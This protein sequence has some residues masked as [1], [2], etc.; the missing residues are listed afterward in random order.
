M[1]DNKTKMPDMSYNL[2]IRRQVQNRHIEGTKEY[3]QYTD[4]LSV[5]GLKPSKLNSDVDIQNL[6]KEFHKQGKYDPNHKDSSPREIVDVGR[7]IGQYWD[8]E[9]QKFIDTSFVKI[10]YSKKGTHI[11]PIKPRGDEK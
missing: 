4:R 3:Q 8:F 7:I 6:I 11:Y 2:T 1:T 10:V 5:L 9:I